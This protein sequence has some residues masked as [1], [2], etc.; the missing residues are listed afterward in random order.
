M[1]AHLFRYTAQVGCTLAAG[2]GSLVLLVLGLSLNPPPDPGARRCCAGT[3]RPWTSVRSGSP[4]PSPRRRR[5]D[6]RHR[7]DRAA[8]GASPRSGAASWTSPR[9]LVL[10][11]LVPLCLAV[12]DV[13]RS[14]RALTS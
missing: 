4:P 12:F 11:T 3:A 2:L 5:P 1:R 7:P 9:R 8:Q 13:Y 14:I 10:L 6:H